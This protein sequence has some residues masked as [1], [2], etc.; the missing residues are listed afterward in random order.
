MAVRRRLQLPFI[1]SLLAAG[2]AIA[3][4]VAP[5]SAASAKVLL[6]TRGEEG[7]GPPA[8]QGETAHITQFVHWPVLQDGCGGADEHATVGKNPAGTVKVSGSDTSIAPF[9]FSEVGAETSTGDVAI[10]SV[11]V[12]KLGAVKLT[13]TLTMSNGECSYRASKLT[14][15]QTFGEENEFTENLTGTGKRIAPS[16]KAC[17]KTTPVE[18]EIGVAN[19]EGYNYVPELTG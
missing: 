8:A 4:P 7:E 17:A 5:A 18:D 14:G 16:A 13:G 11:S 2:A 6:I 1:C 9:C 19:A 3:V 12:S 15:T 10:K